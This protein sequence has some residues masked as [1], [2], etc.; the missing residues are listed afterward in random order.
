[1]V[2][3]DALLPAQVAEVADPA[4]VA[5]P[6][7]RVAARRRALRG[8]ARAR[9]GSTPRTRDA[10]RLALAAPVL[11][12]DALDG[13][14]LDPRDLLGVEAE[15]Q[16]VRRLGRARELRVDRLV[17]PVGLQLEEV[18]RTRATAVGEVRLVDDVR[19]AGADRLLGQPSSLV[20]VEALVVVRRDPDD[21]APLGLEPRQVGGLVLVPLAE[22]Q[23]AV[24]RLELR[25]DEL[26][27]RGRERERRQVRAGEMG[28]E[29][30]RGEAERVVGVQPHGLSIWHSAAP[31]YV[32]SAEPP[33]A[34][35]ST[36]RV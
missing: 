7:V 19:R 32:T 9:A 26:P 35:A 4:V 25:L 30:G 2:V 15:L 12:V 29:V 13:R 3:V 24:R 1:M 8:T 27:A 22:D 11:D 33:T 14:A 20:G 36:P 34:A 17:A 6:R 5:R 28:R 23:V 16:H 18:A 21:R 10:E 31:S